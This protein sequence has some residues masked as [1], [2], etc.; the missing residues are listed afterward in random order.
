MN[1]KCLLSCVFLF[2]AAVVA[3]AQGTAKYQTAG[4]K[5]YNAFMHG[6]EPVYRTAS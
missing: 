1:I 5:W 3:S 2:G 4:G 6:T